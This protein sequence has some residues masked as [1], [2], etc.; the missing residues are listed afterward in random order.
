MWELEVRTICPVFY[1]QRAN[2][3][4]CVDA[5]KA[6]RTRASQLGEVWVLAADVQRQ[7]TGSG[8]WTRTQLEIRTRLYTVQGR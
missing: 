2:N 7:K 4:S 3:A 8:A 1:E 5:H 6:A